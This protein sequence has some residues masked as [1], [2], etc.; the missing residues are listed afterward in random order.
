MIANTKVE[1]ILSP[2]QPAED[3][4]HPSEI[5]AG[6]G[7]RKEGV[8]GSAV[9]YGEKTDDDSGHYDAPNHAYGLVADLFTNFAKE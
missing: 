6:Y 3:G 4:H 9:D 7:K 8:R 1:P 5:I 2:D